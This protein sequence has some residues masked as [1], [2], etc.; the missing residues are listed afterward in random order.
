MRFARFGLLFSILVIGFPVWAQQTQ[1]AMT[2]PRSD[3]QAIAVVQAAI[4]ALGG[5]TAIGQIQ[6]WNIQAHM[7]GLIGFGDTSETITSARQTSSSTTA[8]A[9]RTP[10]YKLEVPSL[11]VPILLSAILLND[12][13][14]QTLSMRSEGTTSLGSAVAP[15]SVVTFTMVGDASL[16]AE[17]WY[18]DG[19]T[20][21]PAMVEFRVSPTLGLIN[22]VV[23]TV[24]PSDFRSVAGTSYPFHLEIDVDDWKQKQIIDVQSIKSGN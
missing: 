2:A 9:P 15:L 20:G 24:R 17:R 13:Q 19:R 22:G 18:F 11:F 1:T 6:S 21:L 14:D 8:L 3:P 5:A 10:P 23:G 12:F 4:T 7:T 16:V